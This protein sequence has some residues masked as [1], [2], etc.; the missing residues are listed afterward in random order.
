VG[1]PD[2]IFFRHT[3]SQGKPGKLTDLHCH[4]GLELLYVLSGNMMHVVE[5]RKYRL[6]PGDLVLV[7]PSRYHYLEQLSDEPYERYN[8][9][10]DPQLEKVDISSLPRE[11]EVINL[12]NVPFASQLF[13]KMDYYQKKLHPPVFK[14]LLLQL[15]KELFISLHLATYAKKREEATLSPILKRALDYINDNLFTIS[16][17]DEVADALFI[18]SSYLFYLFRSSMH[19]TPKKYITVKRLLASQSRIRGGMSP[20]TVCKECGFN[21]YTTFYRN[22]YTF[23]GH[24]PSYD[25][26]QNGIN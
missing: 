11:L 18:S 22:Y 16:D 14:E 8:V 12:K 15:L 23:F 1:L 7:H 20:T 25:S 9:H 13:E 6:E 10:F 24:P 3:V 19:Q 21:E 2:E 26:N 5:G 17:V 4:N